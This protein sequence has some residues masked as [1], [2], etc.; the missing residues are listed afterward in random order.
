[1]K[2]RIFIFM[3][4]MGFITAISNP[5]V[6]AENPKKEKTEKRSVRK[7]TKLSNPKASREARQLYKELLEYH[8]DG[9]ILSGQMWSPWGFDEVE[10]IREQTGKY[11]AVRGH[12]LIIEQNNAREVELLIDWYRR[13][14]DTNANVA[15]G[16]TNQRRGVC[17]EQDGNR[18]K[19]LL[20]RRYG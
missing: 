15:L 2:K 16:S 8:R 12:D 5:T 3:A 19:T 1:M 4:A 20:R 11:P 14:G 7:A 13:G 6:K 18:H 10:Y 17:A 9:K